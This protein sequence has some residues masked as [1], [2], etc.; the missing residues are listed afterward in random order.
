MNPTTVLLI[1]RSSATLQILSILAE[2]HHN[3]RL[4]SGNVFYD[5]LVTLVKHKMPLFQGWQQLLADIDKHGLTYA[6]VCA[7]LSVGVL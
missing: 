1:E 7:C 2:F 3:L 5:Y 6:M 4:M